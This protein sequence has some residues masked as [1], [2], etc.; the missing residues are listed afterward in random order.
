MWDATPKRYL[1]VNSSTD[2]LRRLF[3]VLGWT[4]GKKDTA[5]VQVAALGLVADVSQLAGY[6]KELRRLSKKFERGY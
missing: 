1:N 2:M 3:S 4:L 6:R 5:K